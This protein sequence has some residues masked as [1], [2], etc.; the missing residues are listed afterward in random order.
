MFETKSPR[1]YIP[2]L[3]PGI[4]LPPGGIL[5]RAAIHCG[6]MTTS[7]LDRGP[8]LSIDA[9]AVLKPALLEPESFPSSSRLSLT[10]REMGTESLIPG[11]M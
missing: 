7:Q 6:V 5:Y 4:Y 8:T 11:V 2:R 1:S 9:E 3:F 10:D